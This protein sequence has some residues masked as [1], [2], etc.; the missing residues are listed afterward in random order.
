[1]PRQPQ[2]LLLSLGYDKTPGSNAP[3]GYTITPDQFDR[4]RL[5]SARRMQGE[6]ERRSIK[7]ARNTTL[8]YYGNTNR[9]QRA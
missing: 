7:R 2:S 8:P 4:N 5:Q 1:M 3:G 6:N 9:A